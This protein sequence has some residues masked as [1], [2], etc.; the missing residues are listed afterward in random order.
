MNFVIAAKPHCLTHRHILPCIQS[1][2]LWPC[3]WALAARKLTFVCV[4]RPSDAILE[5]LIGI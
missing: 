1:G 2:D 4:W 5:R 3:S